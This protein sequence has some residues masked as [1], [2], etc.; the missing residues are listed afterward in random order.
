[1]TQTNGRRYTV[2]KQSSGYTHS[3]TYYVYD[4]VK[5]GRVTVHAQPHRDAAQ[6]EADRLEIG[7][8][9]RD[10]EDD[11]RPYVERLAEARARFAAGETAR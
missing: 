8:M 7:A 1:M 3:E 6:S 4:L 9:I 10:Y 5:K 11:S 2:R